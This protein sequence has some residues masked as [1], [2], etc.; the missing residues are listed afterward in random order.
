MKWFYI[1]LLLSGVVVCCILLVQKYGHDADIL[2]VGDQARDFRLDTLT[3]DRFYLN[4]YRGQVVVLAFWATWCSSCK[5]ELMALKTLPEVSS[6]N[7]LMVASICTNPE[8]L[9]SVK[10]I[11]RSLDIS[12]PVLLD[13]G[14]NV[15]R[16]YNLRGY[17][18]TV[19][20]DQQGRVSFIRAGYSSA[21]MKQIAMKVESLLVPDTKARSAEDGT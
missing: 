4:Q 10:A 16:Q 12:Y 7:H 13:T 5:Q 19:I 14:A 3:R 15:F 20:I 17:P 6:P 9:D 18:T 21:I 11:A 2:R 1:L 8:S